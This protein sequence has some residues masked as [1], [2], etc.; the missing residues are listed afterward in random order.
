MGAP[1]KAGLLSFLLAAAIAGL[2]VETAS[3][4][5]QAEP[6]PIDFTGLH[7]QATAALQTLQSAQQQRGAPQET[8]AF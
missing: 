7:S 4:D 1:M 8:A 2:A 3:V 6:E 5:V